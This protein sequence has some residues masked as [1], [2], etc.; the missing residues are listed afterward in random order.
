MSSSGSGPANPRHEQAA[1]GRSPSESG[2]IRS[3]CGPSSGTAPWSSSSPSC[4]YS[5]WSPSCG[6]DR[7]LRG[8]PCHTP[9][10][11]A[12]PDH[13]HRR[14]TADHR[15][16]PQPPG[17][18][19]GGRMNPAISLAM[20]RFGVFPAVGLLPRHGGPAIWFSARGAGHRRCQWWALAWRGGPLDIGL[21]TAALSRS[22][23]TP[24]EA[25]S[26]RG[27]RPSHRLRPDPVPGLTSCTQIAAVLAAAAVGQPPARQVC[28]A[29]SAD[30]RPGHQPDAPGR[31][32]P[33]T[34]LMPSSDLDSDER[35]TRR[36][37]GA[38]SSRIPN[39]RGRDRVVSQ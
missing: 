30:S 5:A 3:R 16:D 14:R 29:G 24:E 6:G 7:P 28:R 2:R 22:G 26:S 37:P 21:F 39:T 25:E 1:L 8:R 15:G 10:P 19:S 17:R 36:L 23:T 20:R 18:A 31:P 32:H 9:H 4:C 11:P 33:G 38:S 35:D 12:A 34:A 27:T 13:R